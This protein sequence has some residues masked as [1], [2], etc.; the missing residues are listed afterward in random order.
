[1]PAALL[2]LNI[3][4]QIRLLIS[5]PVEMLPLISLG[6]TCKMGFKSEPSGS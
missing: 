6:T 4:E 2:L 5:V 1:M 3:F